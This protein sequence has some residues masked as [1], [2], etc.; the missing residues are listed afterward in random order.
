MKVLNKDRSLRDLK[1]INEVYD[2]HADFVEEIIYHH[3][4]KESFKNGI[5]KEVEISNNNF[6]SSSGAREDE[7]QIKLL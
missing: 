7:E 4:Y 3:N 2:K 1:N 6:S 5:L